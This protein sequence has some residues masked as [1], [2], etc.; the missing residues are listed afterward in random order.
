MD[1]AD[2][3]KL[4]KLI[5]PCLTPE[6]LDRYL[7][8][9]LGIEFPWDI[10]DEE[11]TSS[12][13]K[14]LWEAN[15]FM[16]TNEGSNRHVMAVSRNGAKTLSSAVVQYL[17][18][19][20]FR[21]DGV[22][23]AAVLSQAGAL[24]K[25][26]D[27]FMKKP[28][29]MPYL[30]ISN[31]KVKKFEN[32]PPNDFTLRNNAK[33]EVV[34]G[35]IVGA[36]SSRASC[37]EADCMVSVWLKS[38]SYKKKMIDIY[39]DFNAGKKNFVS[40]INHQT[41]KREDK[42][43]INA[44]KIYN[45]D[46]I[47]FTFEDGSTFV[48]TGDHPLTVGHDDI[49]LVYRDAE[50]IETNDHIFKIEETTKKIKITNKIYFKDYTDPYVYDI[51]VKDN[52]NFIADG[53]SVSNCLTFDEIDLTPKEV[54]AE[55]A[56]IA[57]PSTI[58][59]PD[60]TVEKFN[61]LYIYLSSRKTNHGP[62]QDLID[63]AE[64]PII[65]GKKRPTLH[66]WSVAD[67]MQKCPEEIHKPEKGSFKGFLNT[68]TLQTIWKEEDFLK[69]V[70]EGKRSEYKEVK[71]FEGCMD[72]P[73]WI[74]CQGRS[75][76]QKGTSFMLRDKDFVGDVIETVGDAGAIIAQALNWKPE[77][78]GIVFKTF[79]HNKH[80][81]NPIEF[82]KWISFGKWFNP[83][84]LPEEELLAI[85]KSG[86]P[87]KLFDI[88]P[89]KD[90]MYKAFVDNDWFVGAGIDWG[91]DPDPAVCLV[92]GFHKKTQR[93]AVLDINTENLNANH[94]WADKIA[95]TVHTRFPLD[96]V[97]PDQADPSSITYF[98]KHGIPSLGSK[99][100]P[101]RISTGVSF[102]RGLLW[103]PQKNES[104]FAILDDC[105]TD[106][107]NHTLIDGM[108]YWSHAKDPL[109]NYI[110]DKYSDYKNDHPIDAL[111]YILHPFTKS[112]KISF[113]SKQGTQG[114][115][116]DKIRDAI[117]EGD[118]ETVDRLESQVKVENQIDDEFMDKFGIK[119]ATKKPT[120]ES[121][122]K[123]K[124]GGKN[125]KRNTSRVKFSF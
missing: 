101:K 105:E 54:L 114:S 84:N 76:N 100:K 8:D 40:S 53:V 67:I 48:C 43:V 14:F 90:D 106:N 108:M 11:S 5:E 95:E 22:H 24:I 2:Y 25:Y 26:I 27:G 13:L 97:A 31:T 47:R 103:D 72:C 12:S 117:V 62:I 69:T 115:I 81:K 6:D 44:M 71:Y 77:T 60:G 123:A 66:K 80:V 20:H 59:R 50:L 35:T 41:L 79:S 1:S 122:E 45:P 32:L 102:I 96:L 33:L 52:H 10:V 111:R 38:G 9:N 121:I 113:S 37:V 93:A 68:E 92:L 116:R 85:V 58:F 89:T 34:T 21:R 94:V 86:E 110:P 49:G 74:A 16:L 88:T 104:K 119:N 18:L 75:V 4:Q 124:D 98:S 65:K 73:A 51:T 57:D 55:A 78:K 15:R 63:Q 91:Y 70:T 56:F 87:S 23:M 28:L 17:S 112:R 83:D 109:G 19:L 125:K 99:D 3:K 64:A 36:N 30:G 29:L 61:T 82:Y 107:N 39:N 7:Y 46:R 118:K 42:E 120:A